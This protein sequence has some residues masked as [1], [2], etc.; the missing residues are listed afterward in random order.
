MHAADGLVQVQAQYEPSS[1]QRCPVKHAVM[2]WWTKG[3]WIVVWVVCRR[4]ESVVVVV[5]PSADNDLFSANP[6]IWVATLVRPISK[7]ISPVSSS[8]FPPVSAVN[9]CSWQRHLLLCL[10]ATRRFPGL[11]EDSLPRDGGGRTSW[12]GFCD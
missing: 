11:Q 5:D 2:L 6:L 10:C 4:K 9:S 12:F 1:R 3:K 8:P 7:I